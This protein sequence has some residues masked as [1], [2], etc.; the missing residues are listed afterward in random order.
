M[1]NKEELKPKDLKQAPN[2]AQQ[3]QKNDII[4]TNPVKKFNRPVIDWTELSREDSYSPIEEK[5]NKDDIKVGLTKSQVVKVEDKSKRSKTQSKND[6][7]ENEED[8]YFMKIIQR[9]KNND[10]KKKLFDKLCTQIE[11]NIKE[12]F[13]EENKKDENADNSVSSDDED[14]NDSENSYN[15]LEKN[16]L[17]NLL[18]STEKKKRIKILKDSQSNISNNN[19][20]INYNLESKFNKVNS[21]KIDDEKVS[22]LI[23][24]SSA[25][26]DKKDIENENEMK[27][28][29]EIEEQKKKEKEKELQRQKE[30]RE[31]EEREK[32]EKERKEKEREKKEKEEKERHEK[33]IKEKERQEKERQ[34]K[35]RKEREEK[36]RKEKI[37][38]EALEKNNKKVYQNIHIINPNK[39]KYDTPRKLIPMYDPYENNAELPKPP[40]VQPPRQ[41]LE[42]ER[43]KGKSRLPDIQR[44]FSFNRKKFGLG[45]LDVVEPG[46]LVS[47]IK[48]R[49]I[50]DMLIRQSDSN[51][52]SKSTFKGQNERAFDFVS[53]TSFSKKKYDSDNEERKVKITQI[54]KKLNDIIKKM[55]N[56][57]IKIKIGKYFK[58]WKNPSKYIKNMP[59]F[60]GA[61]MLDCAPPPRQERRSS[62]IPIVFLSKSLINETKPFLLEEEKNIESD[63]TNSRID[64]N[65]VNVEKINAEKKENKSANIY[66]K[67]SMPQKVKN[68][69][70]I[71]FVF[72]SQKEYSSQ[73]KENNVSEQK[74]E[75]KNEDQ[76]EEEEEEE[77]EE[78]EK[79]EADYG[80]I[81][82]NGNNIKRKM[83]KFDSKSSISSKSDL[84]SYNNSSNKKNGNDII[85]YFNNKSKEL[86]KSNINNININNESKEKYKLIS[87]EIY[88]LNKAGNRTKNNILHLMN[89]ISGTLFQNINSDIFINLSKKYIKDFG[90]YHIF[91]LYSLF[92]KNHDFYDKRYAFNIWKKIISRPSSKYYNYKNNFNYY[93]C[94][95]FGHCLGCVCH[96]KDNRQAKIKRILIKYIF[97]KEYNPVKYYLYLWYK[98][99]FIR[100]K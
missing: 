93:D 97:M 14:E 22:S 45:N 16:N 15:N 17:N 33:E 3:A 65:F 40:K 52:I 82:N 42:L 76:E 31:K 24:I 53:S 19:E 62:V 73:K 9:K 11:N 43:I 60:H 56:K 70:R 32:I 21:N 55:D 74:S 79:S 6:N 28:Q 81:H 68:G 72:P 92:N 51:I 25:E 67:D 64:N 54:K 69:G 46:E 12:N 26:K 91:T 2:V 18:N 49:Q 30:L 59:S 96:R 36:E 89:N 84:V 5:K 41:V 44:T 50:K 63:D 57:K 78:E 35:E 13:I 39:N 27:R 38:K 90:A 71:E 98:K 4:N 95:N 85:N 29:R 61:T 80:N 10:M 37:E 20:M 8:F 86:K 66:R 99:S 87:Q 75:K 47:N 58:K 1:E 7:D 100:K 77:F 48:L 34:E 23:N 83:I 88:K 94:E